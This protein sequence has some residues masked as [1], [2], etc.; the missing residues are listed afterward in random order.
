LVNE[1]IELMQSLTNPTLILGDVSL[2][3]VVS[4]PIHL[5]VDELVALMQ[6][7]VNPTLLLESEESNKVIMPMQYSTNNT[8]FLE[9]YVSIDHVF[10]ISSL[11]PFE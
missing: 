1:V 7:S 6:Y 2:D 9:R 10:N 11:V 8:L 4:Q 3:H 5:E